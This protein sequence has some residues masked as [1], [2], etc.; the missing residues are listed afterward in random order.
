MSNKD[1]PIK[2]DAELCCKATASLQAQI[3]DD[4]EKR[5][6]PLSTVASG[7]SLSDSFI[8]TVIADYWLG[9]TVKE[10]DEEDENKDD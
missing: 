10:G 3:A 2:C 1:E 6:R 4:M 7:E 9:K 8:R 5:D